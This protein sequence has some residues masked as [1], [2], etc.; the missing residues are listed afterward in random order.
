[1]GSLQQA[2][3]VERGMEMARAARIHA[4]EVIVGGD[5][6]ALAFA[7][8]HRGA[9][10]GVF[11]VGLDLGRH[12]V[13]VARRPGADEAA[14]AM[15]AAVDLLARDDV[16]QHAERV[17]AGSHQLGLQALE[18]LGDRALAAQPFAEVGAAR[19]HAAV[20]R[21]GADPE[22]AALQHDGVD[23]VAAQ[24]ERGREAAIA[25]AHD[26]HVGARRR[27]LRQGVVGRPRLPPPGL[28]LELGVEDVA[29]HPRS[30][31]PCR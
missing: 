16:F 7:R 26:H 10:I 15:Q 20:A 23:A 2:L 18:L 11:V 17:G 31:S 25:G 5:H 28:G 12:I 9:G 14:V 29:A 6:L 24:F 3:V 21:R 19:N 30:P 4:A 8:H 13:V 22:I 27:V 1:M